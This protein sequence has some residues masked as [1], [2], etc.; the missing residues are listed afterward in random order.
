[1]VLLGFFDF[2]DE[3]FG[4]DLSIFVVIIVCFDDMGFFELK[5]KL[6]VLVIGIGEVVYYI[7]F[8]VVV[9]FLV[10]IILLVFVLVLEDNFKY[11]GL[12][13]WCVWV[14]VFDVLVLV[15]EDLNSDVC[16]WIE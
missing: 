14:R 16:Y 12:V 15:L 7:V 1:M 13:N 11:F 10:V 6:F 4:I 5:E 3:K 9:W 8:I 2:F